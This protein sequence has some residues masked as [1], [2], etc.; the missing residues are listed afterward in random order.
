MRQQPQVTRKSRYARLLL[1]ISTL[2]AI[3]LWVGKLKQAMLGVL[4]ILA[5]ARTILRM[6]K[7]GDFGPQ[8]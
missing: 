4:T 6:L 8:S 2:I 7:S 3:A 1:L 5:I